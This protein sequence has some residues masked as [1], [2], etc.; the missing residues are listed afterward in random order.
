M[1]RKR[2]RAPPRG[3]LP[4]VQR[5]RRSITPAVT[6][7]ARSS[8]RASWPG[9]RRVFPAALRDHFLYPLSCGWRCQLPATICAAPSWVSLDL[10][11]RT[12]KRL[13]RYESCTWHVRRCVMRPCIAAC[14]ILP[15]RTLSGSRHARDVVRGEPSR[16]AP[17]NKKAPTK[18]AT[19]ESGYAA[20]FLRWYPS[21]AYLRLHSIQWRV[22]APSAFSTTRVFSVVYGCPLLH[23]SALLR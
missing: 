21:L 17:E 15:G 9:C 1:A 4:A 8:D 2:C 7:P 14:W 12:P 11:H 5:Y 6:L 16:P 19:R 3:V 23:V 10:H 20:C 13:Q 18:K 22:S